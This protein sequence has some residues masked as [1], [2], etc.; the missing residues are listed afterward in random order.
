MR[1]R[2][3]QV[4]AVDRRAVVAVAAHRPQREE[5]IGRHL[6]VQR[7]TA[8]ES[9]RALELERR[10]HLAVQDRAG[11]VG[12]VPADALDRTVGDL[13]G[14]RVPRPF[15]QRVGLREHVDGEDVLAVGR[16]R[17][18]EHARDAELDVRLQRGDTEAHAHLVAVE[19]VERRRQLDQAAV[20]GLD[21]RC[22]CR[23][24]CAGSSASARLIF[25]LTPSQ[26]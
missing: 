17:R 21:S 12:E 24:A 14:D 19:A 9:E 2:A 23:R 6:A 22:R 16:E 26:R 18:V 3:A 11:H 7:V 25:M 10:E 20:V 8:R 5:L 1:P 13:V 4:E 15:G